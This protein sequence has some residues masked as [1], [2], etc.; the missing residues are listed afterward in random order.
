[1]TGLGHED[2]FP[3]PRLSGR[4]RFRKPSFCFRGLRYPPLSLPGL[5]PVC[6]RS[7]L[8]KGG[9]RL[10]RR[11]FESEV[12]GGQ[13]LARMVL[14]VGQLRDAEVVRPRLGSL[15]DA[16]VK[17]DEMPTRR[18]GRL[19]QDLDIALAVEGAGIA[20]IAVVVDHTVDVGGLGPADAL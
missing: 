7:L 10:A 2:E 11:H 13:I 14:R 4:C 8:R 5:N 17:I 19:D 18:A 20:D 9:P 6:P 12:E 1:M 3:G 15:V 16:G